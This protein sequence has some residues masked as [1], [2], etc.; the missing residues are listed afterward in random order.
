MN[1]DCVRKWE[2]AVI[3]GDSEDVVGEI[4]MCGAL[5]GREYVYVSKIVDAI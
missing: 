5:I 3:D 2:L 4:G 1:E